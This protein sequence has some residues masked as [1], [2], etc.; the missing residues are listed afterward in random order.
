W[1]ASF[2]LKGLSAAGRSYA[3]QIAKH[4]DDKP[5]GPTKIHFGGKAASIPMS[6]VEILKKMRGGDSEIYLYPDAQHGFHCDE[7]GS[8]HG[9]SAKTAWQRAMDF[10]EKHLK[11]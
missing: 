10:L 8:F 2:M 3:A 6:E 9:A 4:A 7:R 5:K 11:K 1:L